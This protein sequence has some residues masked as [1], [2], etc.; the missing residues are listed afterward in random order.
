MDGVT[1]YFI[2][3]HSIQ[4]PY[5]VG[6]Y[7]Q[8]ALACLEQ[9]FRKK[10][11]AV[12]V[13]GSGLYIK[14]VCEGMDVMPEVA[15]HYRLDLQVQYEQEGLVPLQEELK[16]KDPL[17]YNEVDLQ[18]PQRVIRAL[19]VCRAT[20][21]PYSQFRKG[22]KAE[23]PFKAIKIGLHLPRPQLYERIDTR[24]D[25]MLKQ[26]LLNEAQALQPY[27]HLNALQTVGYKEI[28]DY[29]DGVYDWEEAVRLL[30]RNSRRYAKR[31]LTWFGQDPEMQWFEPGQYEQILE[32]INQSLKAE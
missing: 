15:S 5:S 18:N 31:Q 13:G 3:S 8:E 27:R 11:I 24:M 1:H 14:A 16:E 25:L 7:E 4:E 6:Q 17:Y 23:R 9:V 28:Y 20:G 22:Q 12:L 26:G 2:N 32:Y 21:L 30:K 19:E 29:L 10:D